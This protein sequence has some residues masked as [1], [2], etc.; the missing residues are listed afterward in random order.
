MPIDFYYCFIDPYFNNWEMAKYYD[1]KCMYQRMFLGINQPKMFFM[2]MNNC[3]VNNKFE[4][5]H[6]N[7]IL[8]SL[9]DYGNEIVVKQANDSEG[10]ANI[11]FVKGENI[12]EKLLN[13]FGKINKDLVIQESI[14]QN[15]AIS[16]INSTSINTIRILSMLTTEGVKIYSCIIR[17]GINGNRVDN[18]SQGGISCGIDDSGRLKK[19]AYNYRGDKYSEHPSSGVR[20]DTVVIPNWGDVLEMVYKA[21]PMI[22]HFRLVSWDIAIDFE[23]KPLLVEANLCYGELNLHQLNN[24]PIFGD[25]TEKVLKD[26]FNY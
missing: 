25:D 7:N 24:G 23:G 16:K 2:R 11:F 21:H 13:A 3:W 4:I 14:K 19:V 6:I 8:S 9:E 12:R 10:G 17:M 1:N 15:K 18:I 5:V 20:F 22:P 26:V